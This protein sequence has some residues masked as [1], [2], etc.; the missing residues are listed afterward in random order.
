M[1]DTLNKNFFN[2]NFLNEHDWA[3]FSKNSHL[4][5]KTIFENKKII[6][7]KMIIVVYGKK[8]GLMDI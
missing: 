5:N 6:T 4:Y 3:I 8:E 7:V 1:R 2:I